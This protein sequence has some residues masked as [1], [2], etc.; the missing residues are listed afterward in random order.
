MSIKNKA[1]AASALLTFALFSLLIALGSCTSEPVPRPAHWAQP[2]ASNALHNWYRLN[3]DV[4]RSEQPTRQGFEEIRRMGIRTILNLRSEQSDAALVEGLGLH[5]VE[6]PME[7]G[8]FGEDEIVRALRAIQTAE[9]PVL[10][11]CQYGSDR[12]GVVMAMYRIVF[13]DWTKEDAL[14]ELKGGGFGF[15]VYYMNIPRFI[16]GA[17]VDGFRERLASGAGKSHEAREV[18]ANHVARAYSEISP[19]LACPVLAVFW[20]AGSRD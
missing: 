6:I 19:G 9:K 11:H 15:H 18:G 3:A 2:V 4:Y 17:D 16:R 7:A 10:V 5:L 8:R 12:T 20:P 1:G 14:A 13:E